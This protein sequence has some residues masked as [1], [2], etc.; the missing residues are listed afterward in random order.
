LND[1]LP[2]L[3]IVIETL[4][5]F[6][7]TPPVV[8][9]TEYVPIEEALRSMVPEDGFIANPPVELNVP[10]ATPVTVGVG[11]ASS[12]QYDDTL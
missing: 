1:A 4:E 12:V 10:P 5:L 11:S 9:V 2:P 6:E 3:E 8:Y 7:Q